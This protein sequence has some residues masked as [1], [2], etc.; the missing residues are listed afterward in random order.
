MRGKL[1]ALS[2]DWWR[3]DTSIVVTD[4][5]EPD[6]PVPLARIKAPAPASRMFAAG[7]L[8]WLLSTD[9]AGGR[10]W[11]SGWDL[12]DPLHPRARGALDVTADIGLPGFGW[13]WGWG[14]QVVCNGRVLAVHRMRGWGPAPAEGAPIGAGGSSDDEVLVYDLTDPDAPHLGGRVVLP[15]GSWSWGLTAAGDRLYLTHFE[16]AGRPDGSGRY[17]LDRIDVADPHRPLLLPP[18]NVP[19]TF[20]AA[21]ADGARVHTLETSWTPDRTTTSLHALDLTDRGT[22]RL[23][24]SVVLDG[25]AGGA[26]VTADAAY[27]ASWD[28]TGSRSVLRLSGIELDPFRLATTQAVEASWAWPLRAGDGWLFLGASGGGG[29]GVLAYRLDAPGHPSFQSF[30]RTSGWA[31]DALVLDGVA[32]LPSGDRG[33]EVVVP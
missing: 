19:G 18:V 3:G 17:Y 13:G 24:G 29:Q 26:L 7:D 9:S 22:A 27:V 32:Y 1:V 21:S 2:G 20:L 30:T 16:W 33:I 11:L 23:A 10:A 15:A 28:W 31:F 8:V 6:A 25:Y 5:A 14:D 12:A 4:P